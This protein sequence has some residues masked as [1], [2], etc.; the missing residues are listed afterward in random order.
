MLIKWFHTFL[1]TAQRPLSTGVGRTQ[2]RAEDRNSSAFSNVLPIR[3]SMKKQR[4]RCLCRA[5]NEGKDPMTRWGRCFTQTQGWLSFVRCENS[6]LLCFLPYLKPQHG[7]CCCMRPQRASDLS[8]GVWL[9]WGGRPDFVTLPQWQARTLIIKEKAR[10]SQHSC[11]SSSRS[12]LPF[13]YLFC[14]PPFIFLLASKEM[15]WVRNV[16]LV[17][18]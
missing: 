6:C 14:P 3:G 10:I 15:I 8:E 11:A 18:V 4:M 17:I 9:G 12:H 16:I 2:V 5:G 13:D 1:W 7:V